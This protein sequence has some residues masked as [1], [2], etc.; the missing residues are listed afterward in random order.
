[1][2]TDTQRHKWLHGNKDGFIAAKSAGYE[3]VAAYGAAGRDVVNTAVMESM[4]TAL[5]MDNYWHLW[6][7]GLR[8]V[9]AA[10]SDA[11]FLEYG[12]DISHIVDTELV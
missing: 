9:Q 10:I 11:V 3:A 5:D 7:E 1:M 8:M 12:I 2:V 6:A 4:L